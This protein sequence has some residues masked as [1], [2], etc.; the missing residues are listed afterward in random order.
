MKSRERSIHS[1]KYI[2]SM[3]ILAVILPMYLCVGIISGFYIN[4]YKGQSDAARENT[5]MIQLNTLETSLD[6]IQRTVSNYYTKNL[7]A[8]YKKAKNS[9]LELYFFQQQRGQDQC[10]KGIF[11]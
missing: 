4:L 8:G 10:P 9:E 5:L 6:N 7:S 1:L 3:L 11:S 2:L